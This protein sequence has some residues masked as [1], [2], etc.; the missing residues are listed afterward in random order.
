[1]MATYAIGDIQGCFSALEKLLLHIHFDSANDTLWLTG[2]LVNRGLESLETLRFVKSLGARHKI[3]LGNHDLHL[4]AV[5]YGMSEMR[6]SDTLE[7]ILSAPD[8]N[9][10][11]DWL[12]HCPLLVHDDK[13]GYVMTHAGLAPVWTVQKAALLAREVEAVLQSDS[14]E[15]WFK[16]MYG[17]HPNQWDD[18]LQGA[19]RLRCIVN[20]FTRMRFCHHD[21]S[22]ELTYKGEINNKPQEL[23]PWFEVTPRANAEAKIIFGHWASLAGKTDAPN[24]YALDTGCVWG[25]CLTAMRLEDGRRFKVSC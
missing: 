3:V 10:L 4:L 22:L 6:K 24:V 15:A 25:Q 5:A 14:P 20:Y 13:T 12:R 9:E 23:I 1:M 16:Q 2:D 18:Q 8:R 21:G 17:N 19:E 7:S 11:I